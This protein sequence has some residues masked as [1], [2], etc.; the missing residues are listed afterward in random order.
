MRDQDTLVFVEV[1]YRT[2]LHYGESAE[3]VV[4]R[5]QHRLIRAAWQYLLETQSVDQVNG[6]F[7]ILGLDASGQIDW[8]KNAFEVEY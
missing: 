1:R 6:R 2:D 3:T 8:I 7:D 4:W 5:K